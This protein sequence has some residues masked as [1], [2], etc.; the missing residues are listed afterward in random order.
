MGQIKLVAIDLDGTFLTDEKSITEENKRTLQAAI[1]QGIKIVICTGRTLPGVRRFLQQLPFFEEGDYIILQNGAATHALPGLEIVAQQT[2]PATSRAQ[3]W[4]I[5][6]AFRNQGVQLVAFNQ[7]DMFLVDETQ[8]SE[9]VQKD[10]E[11]LDTAIQPISC[12]Q[13]LAGEDLNKMMVLGSPEVLDKLEQAIPTEFHQLV[14]VVRS[15]AII[16]EFLPKGVN[17]RSALESLVNQL[18]LEAHNV[19][20]IGDQLNDIEMLEYAGLSVAMANAVPKVQTVADVVT[21]SNNESGVAHI[22]QQKVL[23]I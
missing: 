21:K 22:I 12:E 16:V 11:T 3:A 19:M 2:V 1:A 8:P 6:Q 13:F 18:G 7:D 10:A 23:T 9:I 15:Q 17:K 14:N 20:A 4:D 5:L